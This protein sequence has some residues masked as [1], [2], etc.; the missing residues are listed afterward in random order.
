MCVSS[1]LMIV[2]ICSVGWKI[3]MSI[4]ISRMRKKFGKKIKLLKIYV[5]KEYIEF[6]KADDP[7]AEYEEQL[8]SVS[9]IE[10][11]YDE[12]EETTE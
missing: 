9:S 6:T 5:E 2:H 11:D 7:D 8:S 3:E 1:M 10:E 4:D 12:D